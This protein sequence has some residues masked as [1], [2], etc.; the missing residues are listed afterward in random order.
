MKLGQINAKAIGLPDARDDPAR[1]SMAFVTGWGTTQEGGSLPRVLQAVDVPIVH[2][3]A[4]NK[5]YN[6][7][8]T[9]HMIC[10]G[11]PNGG[12]DSCQVY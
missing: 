7:K 12:K 9:R 8:I 2:R 1:D 11:F 5:Q 4:C 3:D 10:A 6:G